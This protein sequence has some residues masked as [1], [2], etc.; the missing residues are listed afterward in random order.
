MIDL[1]TAQLQAPHLYRGWL[2]VSLARLEQADEIMVKAHDVPQIVFSRKRDFY[3]QV[4]QLDYVIDASHVLPEPGLQSINL[5]L[6]GQVPVRLSGSPDELLTAAHPEFSIQPP[7][8]KGKR[9][10]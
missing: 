3:K 1:E 8:R 5:T 9:D 2:I 6:E 10:L 7:Q 4:A